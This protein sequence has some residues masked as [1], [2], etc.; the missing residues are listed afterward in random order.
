MYDVYIW[1]YI[2]ISILITYNP[3]KSPFLT[4][5]RSDTGTEYL[6]S[7]LV[8]AKIINQFVHQ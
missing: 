2:W 7:R 1:I 3:I 5:I 8:S 4:G 6:I